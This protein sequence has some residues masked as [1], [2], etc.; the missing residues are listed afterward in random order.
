MNALLRLRRIGDEFSFV[1]FLR[2]G[3]QF[4][5]LNR[6]E[7]LASIR[8]PVC[9]RNVVAQVKEQQQ[10]AGDEQDARKGVHQLLLSERLTWLI[11]SGTV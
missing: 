7:L 8:N 3:E 11:Q 2:H 9:D 5:H 1:I 10:G 4:L 6:A